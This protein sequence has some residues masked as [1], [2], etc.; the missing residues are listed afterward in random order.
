M[1][2]TALYFSSVVVLA[3]ILFAPKS[4]AFIPLPTL[5][6]SSIVQAIK[7]G[8]EQIKSSKVIVETTKTVAKVSSSIGD[9]VSTVSKFTN[10]AKDQMA[11]VEKMRKQAEEYKEQYEEYKG[12]AEAQVEKAKALKDAAEDGVKMAQE[13]ADILADKDENK[14]LFSSAEKS[15]GANDLAEGNELLTPPEDNETTAEETEQEEEES[16]NSVEELQPAA[17]NKFLK[18]RP[19]NVMQAAPVSADKALK[20]PATQKE[21]VSAISEPKAMPK[22]DAAG[23]LKAAQEAKPA[24]LDK[25]AAAKSPALSGAKVDVKPAAPVSEKKAFRKMQKQS[26]ADEYIFFYEQKSVIASADLLET[27]EKQSK[28]KTGRA[29]NGNIILP[30]SLA[31][32]CEMTIDEVEKDTDK[33]EECLKE[34]LAKENEDGSTG[35]SVSADE[36][37]EFRKDNTFGAMSMIVKAANK[38]ANYEEKVIADLQEAADGATEVR[39]SMTVSAHQAIE[40]AKVA[41][42]YVWLRTIYGRY[43][44]L[45]GIEDFVFEEK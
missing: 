16:D 39:S 26:S 4:Y 14:S 3:T 17:S 21:N 15:Y 18:N 9:A 37:L 45:D 28:L 1:K 29:G 42:D 13:R 25:A 36:L 31:A 2:K 44:E 30:K 12:F 43:N 27:T 24:S 34:V 33:L 35:A 38:A 11:E 6:T 41:N 23:G 40:M 32:Y 20:A 19:N 22:A 7:S 8:I 5:D 10:E